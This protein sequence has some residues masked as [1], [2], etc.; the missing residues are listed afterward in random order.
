M[1]KEE[2]NPKQAAAN[3]EAVYEAPAIETIVKPT[4]ME[5]EYHYAGAIAP[6][7]LR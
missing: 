4:D 2:T 7:Q 1:K 5:R 6:S 3:D